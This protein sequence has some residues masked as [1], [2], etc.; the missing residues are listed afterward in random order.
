MRTW[1]YSLHTGG[2]RI[3]PAVKA[4]TEQRILDYAA[5]HHRGK[6]TRIDVR[7]DRASSQYAHTSLPDSRRQRTCSEASPREAETSPK[8]KM[9][10][11]DPIPS[12]AHHR[13]ARH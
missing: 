6:F 2:K 12:L 7:M 8:K 9:V 10:P 11:S 5:R 3:P 4:R 13:H 1:V